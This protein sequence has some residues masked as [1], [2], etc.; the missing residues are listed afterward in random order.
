MARLMSDATQV[1][2][3]RGASL[4]SCHTHQDEKEHS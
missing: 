4:V 3:L 1:H 2:T